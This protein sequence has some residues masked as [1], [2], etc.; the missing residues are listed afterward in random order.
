[1]ILEK[2]NVEDRGKDFKENIIYSFIHLCI[3]E[4]FIKYLLSVAM[5]SQSSIAL[6]F[7]LFGILLIV[8]FANSRIH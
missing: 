1:M 7:H 2:V 8:L 4:E 6:I 3:Q 5:L